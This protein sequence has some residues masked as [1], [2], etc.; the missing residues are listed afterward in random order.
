METM[1]EEINQLTNS[2]N[3]SDSVRGELENQIQ[4]YQQE[5]RNL[6]FSIFLLI[7]I[8]AG[9]VAQSGIYSKGCFVPH[10]I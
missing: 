6:V 7:K 4:K 1:K 10:I 3:N 2:V 5:V 8:I 9:E